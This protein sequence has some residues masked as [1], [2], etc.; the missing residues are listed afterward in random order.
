MSKTLEI[1]PVDFKTVCE[2][3]KKYHRHHQPPQGY[4]FLLGI[5][6]IQ[7]N[8]LVGVAVIGRPVARMLDD[9]WTLEITRLCTDGTYNACSKLLG[10]ACRIAKILG[11]KKVITYTLPEEG[12]A[13]LRAAGFNLTGICHGRSWNTPSRPRIDKTPVQKHDKWRWEKN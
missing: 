8:K 10:T 3:I 11:Y 1:I 13:S 4:K 2:F 6:D 12:G 5:K 9:G 7:R